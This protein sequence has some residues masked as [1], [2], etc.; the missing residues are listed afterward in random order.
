MLHGCRRAAAHGRT[1]RCRTHRLAAARR[2]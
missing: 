1:P 2:V